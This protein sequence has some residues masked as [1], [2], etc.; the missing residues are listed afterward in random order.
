VGRANGSVSIIATAVSSS[1]PTSGPV[2]PNCGRRIAA[3]RKD[4]CVYCGA[5]F[6][7]DL[8][9]G[10]AEPE[11]LKWVE[12]PNLPPEASRQLEMMKVIPMERPKRS[13]AAIFGFLALPIF[14]VVFYLLYKIVERHS[15]AVAV[16]I[17]VA[18]VAFLGYLGWTFFKRSS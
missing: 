2:C 3:W 9:A 14:A 5:V 10:F 7:P 11:A 18:G 16:L 13:P 15:A 17:A 1:T 12:R 4:H 8:K 6:P